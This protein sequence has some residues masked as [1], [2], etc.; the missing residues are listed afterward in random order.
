MDMFEPTKEKRTPKFRKTTVEQFLHTVNLM[1]LRNQSFTAAAKRLG[2]SSASMSSIRIA[3]RNGTFKTI[4][5]LTEAELSKVK[6]ADT[7]LLN[8]SEAPE[9]PVEDDNVICV[10]GPPDKVV[11]AFNKILEHKRQGRY[12]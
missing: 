5:P 1:K 11:E 6:E 9:E 2:F 3:L 4:Q 10:Y 7:W 8:H 12:L